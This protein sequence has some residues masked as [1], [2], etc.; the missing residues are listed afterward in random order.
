MC[1]ALD[2]LA[3]LQHQA[4]TTHLAR[5]DCCRAGFHGSPDVWTRDV[6]NLGVRP[7]RLV[8]RVGV[9][10]G[11]WAGACAVHL[12][13]GVALTFPI[14]PAPGIHSRG[15]YLMHPKPAFTLQARRKFEAIGGR[16]LERTPLNG[17]WVHPNGVGLD[18]GSSSS[19]SGPSSS[20]SSSTAGAPSASASGSAAHASSSG[21]STVGGSRQVTSRLVL[22]CMGH[23]SPIVRQIRHGQKPDGVCLVVGTCARGFPAD[24]NTSGE[25][26]RGGGRDGRN[27]SCLAGWAEP[28]AG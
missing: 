25:L 22:D 6:L 26:G 16:I 13:M 11:R 28:G 4:H 7:D 8:E 2:Y 27:H 3:A 17:L 21:S 9:R 20:G 19:S 10:A 15:G 12:C 18:I 23:A 5:G 24:K 1:A 14:E